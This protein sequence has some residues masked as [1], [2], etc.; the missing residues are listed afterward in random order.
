MAIL[1]DIEGTEIYAGRGKYSRRAR[2]MIQDRVAYKHND[3]G[4][5]VV[6][7][8]DNNLLPQYE[9]LPLMKMHTNSSVMH[10]DWVNNLD[11]VLMN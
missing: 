1:Y 8:P 10:N 11:L 6:H 9:L 7:V 4:N 3:E 5:L 2:S